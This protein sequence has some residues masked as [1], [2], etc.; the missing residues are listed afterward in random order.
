MEK[1]IAH[2]FAT[3]KDSKE[4]FSTS[5]GFLFHK[6]HDAKAHAD[7]L[8]DKEVEKH[9]RKDYPAVNEGD[10]DKLAADEKKAADKKA[11][12]EKKAAEGK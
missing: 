10:A 3:Y 11:A 9:D 12:D 2:Y 1:K 6:E 8:G 5:N 4:C 7:T